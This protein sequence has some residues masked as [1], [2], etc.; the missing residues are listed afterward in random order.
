[1]STADFLLS[2]KP[3][4]R[5]I[6]HLVFWI[7]YCT[8]FFVQSWAPKKFNEFFIGDTYYFAFLNLCCFAP[9]FIFAV[10]LSIG[11]LLPRILMKKRYF[12]FLFG[13]LL[14][15]AAGSF[16]NYFMAGVFL[17]HVH[18][19]TP[20][21]ANFEHRMEFGSYNTRWGMVIAIIAIG[22]K[23][24]KK[25]YVQKKENLEMLKKKTRTEMQLQKARIHPEFLLRS[26]NTIY[27]HIQSGSDEA[28]SMILN[29]A[30]LLSY[31]LYENGKELVPLKKE[32]AQLNNFISL[33]KQ[34]MGER[35]DGYLKKN[36][37]GHNKY[38]VPLVI[39]KLLEECMALLNKNEHAGRF[40]RVQTF[41]NNRQVIV[42]MFIDC[43]PGGR[44]VITNWC[45]LVENA[46]RR[47][48]EYYTQ[49]DFK[50][51]LSENMSEIVITLHINLSNNS[52]G[53]NIVTSGNGK[54]V[55]YDT[56]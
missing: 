36:D 27:N 22:I 16:I 13:L 55:M 8:Y 31:S 21:S 35:I 20:I 40:I 5:I 39:V 14:V 34:S 9:V 38:I 45:V 56:V 52:K 29:L 50:I 51:T 53:L 19:S 42:N 49:N 48:S 15:Y 2:N 32:L 7:V 41:S 43:I 37:D 47:L 33:E 24:T 12:L 11:F 18:Y 28:P 23:L 1:M 6:R 26:L 25:L 17:N 10:Y 3:S 4:Y 44:P 54:V 46:K 30:D